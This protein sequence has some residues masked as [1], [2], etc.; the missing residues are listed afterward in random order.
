MIRNILERIFHRSELERLRLL[1][2]LLKG[3]EVPLSQ[4]E[5]K[6]IFDALCFP[7][8]KQKVYTPSTKRF[9]REIYRNLKAKIAASIK[10]MG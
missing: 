6:M 7:G 1:N 5:R 3:K 4:F 2:G 10:E 8:Y 9:I